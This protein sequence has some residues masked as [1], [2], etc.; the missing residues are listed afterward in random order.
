VFE[1]ENEL[2]EQ[3]GTERVGELIRENQNLPMSELAQLLF[4]E[5]TE[6]GAHAPQADDITILL[7]RRL[8]E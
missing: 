8:P 6:F 7:V 1:T 3:L 5:A 2:G 4:D